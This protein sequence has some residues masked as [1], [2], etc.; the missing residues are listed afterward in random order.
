MIANTQKDNLHWYKLIILNT[1]KMCYKDLSI[2]DVLCD[3]N[4]LF[5]R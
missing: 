3:P 5:W 1:Q 2:P 4:D